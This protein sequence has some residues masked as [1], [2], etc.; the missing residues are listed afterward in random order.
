[1]PSLKLTT[2]CDLTEEI[3]YKP[4]EYRTNG[5]KTCWECDTA[6]RRSRNI[7]KRP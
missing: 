2:L 3:E 4:A 1:M 7:P 6:Y 5:V